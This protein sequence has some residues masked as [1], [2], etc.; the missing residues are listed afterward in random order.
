LSLTSFHFRLFSI[1]V[2]GFDK[3]GTLTSDEMRLRGIRLFHDKTSPDGDVINDVDEDDLLV[4]PDGGNIPWETNRVMAACHSLA[5]AGTAQGLRVIGDPLEQAVLTHTGFRLRGSNIV[6]PIP[7]NQQN[8]N[9]IHIL[10]RF[11]F[12]SKLKRMTVLVTEAEGNNIV[13]ALTKGAPET[14]K[15][16]LAAS[17][18]PAT[19][20]E[21]SF[22]HMSRGRRVLA[23]AYRKVGSVRDLNTMKEKGRDAVERDLTFGGFLVLDC[24]LKPDSKTI[25][26]ELKKSNHDVVM[27]TG[28]AILT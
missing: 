20:D 19:Y 4:H 28:D 6:A 18:V 2:T 27:I 13:W 22:Y 15:A 16:L 8:S 24:P 3:T 11:A 25:I 17:A 26:L 21:T 12:S 1:P 9:P 23:M 10:H 14:I 7:D 5:I